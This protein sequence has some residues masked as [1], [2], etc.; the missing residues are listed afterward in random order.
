MDYTVH[1]ILQARI[2]EWV[3]FPFSSRSS[4]PRDRTRVSCIAGGFC[5]N[6][7]IREAQIVVHPRG[8]WTSQKTHQ[9]SARMDRNPGWVE[10]LICYKWCLV[11]N[12]IGV[13]PGIYFPLPA[14]WFET[15]WSRNYFSLIMKTILHIYP[16]YNLV[17]VYMSI[18]QP[19]NI[20]QHDSWLWSK[21]SA[22]FVL[23]SVIQ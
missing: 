5:T 10:C 16:Y 18:I 21:I 15:I 1:G 14:R 22:S 4:Q 2:L 17:H 9:I 3:A 19:I 6:W 13:T 12:S 8:R 20:K 23:H 11:S 7:A